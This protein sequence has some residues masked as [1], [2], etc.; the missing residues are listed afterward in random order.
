[1]LFRMDLPYFSHMYKSN[2]WNGENMRKCADR[3]PGR[4][5]NVVFCSQI[6]LFTYIRL[7]TRDPRTHQIKIIWNIPF[8]G[9]FFPIKTKTKIV[10]GPKF[11]WNEDQLA[12]MEILKL[13]R[14]KVPS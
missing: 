2:R 5:N 1:M 14:R 9:N 8:Y 11:A 12:T 3:M 6:F 13:L 7:M 10:Y 4:F